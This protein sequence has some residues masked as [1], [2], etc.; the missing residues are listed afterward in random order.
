[1]REIKS[2]WMRW[3]GHVAHL[4]EKRNIYKIFVGKLEDIDHLR[5]QA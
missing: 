1:M 4:G 3:V 5:V 2:R